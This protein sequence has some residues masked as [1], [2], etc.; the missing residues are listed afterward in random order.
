MG[1][2][3]WGG[4]H[5]ME[6]ALRNA[7]HAELVSIA[8]REDWWESD[9]GLHFSE[10]QR[11]RDAITQA[12]GLKGEQMQVGHVVAELSLGFWSALLA[13]CYHQR[14]GGRGLSG[15]FPMLKEKR[16]ELHRKVESLRK[17]RNRIAHHEPI[18]AR[19]PLRDHAGSLS[20]IGAISPDIVSWVEL[21][22]RVPGVVSDRDAIVAG[23][24]ETTF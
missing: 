6:V 16:R 23:E 7:V 14:L 8:G 4:F 9:T 1:S 22:S 3:S 15:V 18:H 10:I 21:N 5:V 24:K 17:L 12:R 13:N 20:V 19:D 11:I 2:A